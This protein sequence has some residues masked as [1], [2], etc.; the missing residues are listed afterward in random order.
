MRRTS[1]Y[2]NVAFA[3]LLSPVLLLAQAPAQAPA[4]A[5]P[6][7]GPGAAAGQRGAPSPANVAFHNE[8]NDMRHQGFVDIAKRGNIF[9]CRR[10][11]HRLV[12]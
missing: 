6:A 10:L 11:D 9:F 1:V 4:G 5:P 12:L 2:L 8:R 7:G 3:L